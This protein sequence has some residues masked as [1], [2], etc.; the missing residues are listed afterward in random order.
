MTE[1]TKGRLVAAALRTYESLLA[2][3]L[4]DPSLNVTEED[5]YKAELDLVG[6][7]LEDMS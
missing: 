5:W 2:E 1:K 3:S 7:L 6:Q 4:E